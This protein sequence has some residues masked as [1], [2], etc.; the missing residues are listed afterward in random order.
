ERDKGEL[1]RIVALGEST[2]F[3]VILRPGDRPWPELL[4]ARIA[5]ELACDR[6]VQVVNG[7]VPG[8]TLG[9]QVIRLKYDVL[10]LAPDI[11]LSYHG[12]NGFNFFLK[13]LP[14]V[15]VQQ[16]PVPPRRGSLLLGRLEDAVRAGWFQRRYHALTQ[17]DA[18]VSDGSLQQTPYAN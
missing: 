9:N 12:F 11:V 16:S 2:T 18:S 17:V 4:G 14:E 8:W 5:D 13:E 6:P 1:F 10:S 3:D 7:G 15:T